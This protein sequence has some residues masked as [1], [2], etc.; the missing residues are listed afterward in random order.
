[1]RKVTCTNRN[2]NSIV[3]GETAFEPFLLAH[4]DGLYNTKNEVSVLENAVLDG[5]DYQ[6]SRMKTR[7]IVLTISDRPEVVYGMKNRDLLRQ[8]F[9]KGMAGTMVYEEDGEKR[10]IDYYVESIEKG[11][12]A[13][14]VIS[15]LCPDPYLYDMEYTNLTF[16]SVVSRF[17]FPHQFKAE[18]EEIS[19]K[20]VTKTQISIYGQSM[21][22]LGMIFRI[23]AEGD[24][25]N[26]SIV[27][28]MT[29]EEFT[30]GT[31]ERPF[32]LVRGDV[33]TITTEDGRKGV[34]LKRD[35]VETSVNQ[36][37][38]EDSKFIQIN[39]GDNYFGYKADVGFDNVSLQI[40][41]RN[42]YEGA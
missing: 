12:R 5:S 13:L 1:M 23:T 7:N 36:H 16:T 40:S 2:G 8:V 14:Y 31:E 28:I 9:S 41:Y 3:F 22:P 26:P 42:R 37:I 20:E 27:N 35:G 29:S 33:L 21:T 30:L 24:V 11:K 18:G 39:Y 34:T 4:I 19:I 25:V 17:Q 10:C 6:G 38:T 15:L 32:R